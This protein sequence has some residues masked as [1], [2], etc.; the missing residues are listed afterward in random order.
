MRVINIKLAVDA[1]QLFR[2]QS[3]FVTDQLKKKN[4]QH[5]NFNNKLLDP[6]LENPLPT[7]LQPSLLPDVSIFWLED[8]TNGA[9]PS[10][11]T[12]DRQHKRSAVSAMGPVNSYKCG[13]AYKT[14]C[15]YNL[16]HLSSHDTVPEMKLFYM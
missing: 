10:A 2:L 14:A 12:D 15:K 8:K 9:W 1:Y 3:R 16:L 13:R 6:S 5:L 7:T 11:I 4:R